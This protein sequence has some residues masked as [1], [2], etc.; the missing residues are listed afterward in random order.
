[1]KILVAIDFDEIAE[2]VENVAFGLAQRLNG[3]VE[4][5]NIVDKNIRYAPVSAPFDFAVAWQVQCDKAKT[6]LEKIQLRHSTIACNI[7]TL[8]G[9]PKEDIIN[10]A[11]EV[12]AGMIILGTHGRTGFAGLLLG[13]TAEYIVRHSTV[14]VLVVPHKHTQH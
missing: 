13:S 4:L 9:D 7:L 8:V 3:E 11:T 1:M 2:D 10:K 14:P 5:V 6:S 12:K